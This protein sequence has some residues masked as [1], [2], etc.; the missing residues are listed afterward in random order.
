MFIKHQDSAW[1]TVNAQ[2]VSAVIFYVAGHLSV[3]PASANPG[4][5]GSCTFTSCHDLDGTLLGG[6]M[7]AWSQGPWPPAIL[8]VIP[9]HHT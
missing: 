9:S 4:G 3:A 1:H 5:P 6:E 8:A 2:E 7:L